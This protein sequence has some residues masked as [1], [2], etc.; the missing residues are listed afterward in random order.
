CMVHSG[1]EA[2]AVADTVKHP[3]KALGVKLRGIKTDGP[4]APDIPLDRQRP[5]QF[6]FSKHVEERLAEIKAANPRARK[7][8]RTH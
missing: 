2:S 5:A 4:M 6:V 7:V 1:F 3:M 8:A